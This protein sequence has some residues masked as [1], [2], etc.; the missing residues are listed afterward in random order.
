MDRALAGRDRA[1][2]LLDRYGRLLT[3][4][5]REFLVRYYQDDLSLG[6][7]ATQLHISRQAVH[8]GLRR[9][10]GML[11]RFEAALGLVAGA[12]RAGTEHYFSRTP[13]SAAQ[14][15]T[16]R[17]TLRGRPWAFQVARGVFARRGV[18]AGTRLVI[19]TM[20]IDPTDR[21]LDLGCGYGAIGLVAAALAP[22][23]SAWLIDA[24]ARAA[25]LARANAAA[26]HLANVAVL[27]GDRAA[28]IR[29]ASMDV[30]VTNPPIRAGRRVV[31][32]F[33]DDAHRVLR[34]GGRFY[35]V[36]RTAQGARTLARLIEAR[37]GSVRQAALRAGY[38]VYEARRG[39][40]PAGV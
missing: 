37:F 35:L 24:N 10:L 19:E 21:V 15:R 31:T 2:R 5:Q 39:P 8:D 38:R 11:E 9:A 22:R 33:I 20:Q 18:D 16:V 27:V 1:N 4:R 32:A 14:P 30:V 40:E 36:A 34:P 29:N 28:A 7:I 13:R 17:A 26:N 12:Q 25:A 23:G 6:E 3:T